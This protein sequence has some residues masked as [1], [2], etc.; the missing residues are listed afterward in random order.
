MNCDMV[1]HNTK[2]SC[3]CIN[4]SLRRQL[5][6]SFSFELFK[7]VLED[8]FNRRK[9]S[10][11]SH[12]KCLSTK[13]IFVVIKRANFDQVRRWSAWYERIIG[14]LLACVITVLYRTIGL[15]GTWYS[16]YLRVWLF[17]AG[18]QSETALFFRSTT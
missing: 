10:K 8:F 4:K 11:R 1:H 14:L 12:A 9:A 18:L 5:V 3:V 7:I 16:G 17:R 13:E 2:A 15:S 6:F